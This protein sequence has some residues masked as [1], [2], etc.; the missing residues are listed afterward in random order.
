M[1]KHTISEV[2]RAMG[3]KGGKIGGRRSMV[4][5]TPEER[6]ARA[7]VAAAAS[8]VARSKKKRK[9]VPFI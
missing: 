5:M 4:T 9:S 2:M 3:R 8:V 6:T 1:D 7:M